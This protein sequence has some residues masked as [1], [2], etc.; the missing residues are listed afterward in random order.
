MNE[1][2]PPCVA[3]ADS[4]I[5][6]FCFFRLSF[7]FLLFSSP[8][9][10]GRRLPYFYTRC[11]PNANL[12]CRSE[13]CCTR[14]AGNA[15]RK[16]SPKIGYLR[17]IVFFDYNFSGWILYGSFEFCVAVCSRSSSAW[18]FLEHIFHKVG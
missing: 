17:T 3:D 8:N 15:W 10:S 7:F 14:L 12:E 13:M 6:L 5:L 2:W 16:K 11:G 4:I 1:L 9:L 18:R